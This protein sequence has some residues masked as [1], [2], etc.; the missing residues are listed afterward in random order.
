MWMKVE[1]QYPGYVELFIVGGSPESHS[2]TNSGRLFRQQG[3]S[4]VNIQ[5]CG[6]D[7]ETGRATPH[8]SGHG[9][10]IFAFLLIPGLLLS[11]SKVED[12]GWPRWRG[13]NGDG[14]SLETDWDPKALAGGPKILWKANVGLGY[15]NVVIRD[16][17]LY[18]IGS[19]GVVCL[20]AETGEQIWLFDDKDIFDPQPTPTIDGNSVYVLSNKG[21]LWRLNAKNGKVRWKK[22]LISEYDVTKPFYKFAGSPVIDGDLL[23]ITANTSGIALN[24]KTGNK[25]WDSRK[26]PK[27]IRA[28]WDN[29]TK[30]TDYSTP[31]IY[32][33]EEKRYAG[34]FSYK[35]LH[36]VDVETGRPLWLYEWSELYSGRHIADPL[37]F[38]N[39]VF[40]TDF[41]SRAVEFECVL[42]DIAGGRPK[43]IWKNQNLGS[44]ISSPVM[45]DGYIYGS[46]GGP[47]MGSTSLRCLD[48]ETGKL[49]WEKNLGR[50][51]VSLTASDG[52]LIIL[53]DNGT[54]RI[55]EAT[56]TEYREISSCKLPSESGKNRWWTPPVLYR[57]RIYCRNYAGDLVCIDVSKRS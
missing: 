47:D 57:S 2:A 20:N 35:G 23:I 41:S 40:I 3:V 43:V 51:V 4:M 18:A 34:V 7:I 32:D 33:Y 26:P 49:M 10:R 21:I 25:V 39:K 36:F 50:D 12:V 6:Q 30:G 29:V 19:I 24:R 28:Y 13:P 15:A 5:L 44:E 9:M 31:V 27:K 38:D 54:V 48:V 53:E 22:D 16:N 14:I 37:I 45:I 8:I 17:R 56:P 42:L 55:A 1:W 11:C 52:K 46:H